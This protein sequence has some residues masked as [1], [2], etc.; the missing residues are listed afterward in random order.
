MSP[1]IARQTGDNTAYFRK[2][3]HCF[4]Q[5]ERGV[6]MEVVRET[7]EDSL[8]AGRISLLQQRRGHR[9]GTDAV[10]LAAIAASIPA[11][12]IVDVGAASG[13]IGLML[14]DAKKE[15]AITCLEQDAFLAELCQ[16]N[17]EKNGFSGRMQAVTADIFDK[18]AL[19]QANI[20]PEMADLVVTN[21]PFLEEGQARISP[22]EHRRKAHALPKEG[23]SLW[24]STCA[25]LVKPKGTLALIHRADNLPACLAAIPQGFGALRVTMIHPREGE[26]AVRVIV[27]T[28]R[29]RKDPAIIEAPLFL[30]GA[31]GR[32]TKE[33]QALHEGHWLPSV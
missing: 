26:A 24:I 31:D 16:R 30:H 1:H 6:P 23:L 21:P 25:R 7:T 19:R 4:M 13:A 3:L 27:C 22:D 32:F 18:D 12:T 29:G 2:A 20:L 15:V 17:I 14:A 33:A 28:T 5:V 9:A 8:L 10:L 11:D